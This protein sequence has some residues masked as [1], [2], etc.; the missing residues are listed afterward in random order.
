MVSND[1]SWETVKRKLLGQSLMKEVG[2]VQN[3]TSL[4][5]KFLDLF[6]GLGKV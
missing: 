6:N 3:L 4:F 5:V 1:L 2:V